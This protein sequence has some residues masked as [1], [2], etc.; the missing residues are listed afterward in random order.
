MD[1]NKASNIQVLDSRELTNIAD[2]MIISS[3][4][5]S[6]HII[7]VTE[8]LVEETKKNNVQP[9]G[10]EGK[11]YGEWVLID[12]G[13]IIVHIMSPEMRDYYRLEQLWSLIDGTEFK[14]ALSSDQ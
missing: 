3:G 8:K 10:I 5:S 4:R 9:F 1:D 14:Y 6:R 12:L 7:S 13:D 2:L 11:Q